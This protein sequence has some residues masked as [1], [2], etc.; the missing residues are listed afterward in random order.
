MGAVVNM[1]PDLI[2]SRTQPFLCRRYEY[3]DGR[4]LAVDHRQMP[5]WGNPNEKDGFTTTCAAIRRMTISR[6][7]YP[8][9][10]GDDWSQH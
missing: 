4:Q 3:H 6:K 10:V 1:R 8:E 9:H 5:G 2:Q 7:T